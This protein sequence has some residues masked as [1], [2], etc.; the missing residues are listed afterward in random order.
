[1]TIIDSF[2][3]LQPFL[4]WLNN[5]YYIGFSKPLW[6]MDITFWVI[7]PLCIIPSHL[8]HINKHFRSCLLS[9]GKKTFNTTIKSDTQKNE[10]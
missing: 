9:I 7:V 4:V 5:P 1:M 10:T 6:I 8:F 3:Q 2:E